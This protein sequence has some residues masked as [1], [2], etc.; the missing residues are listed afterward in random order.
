LQSQSK[1][2]KIHRMVTFVM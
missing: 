1:S 2:A